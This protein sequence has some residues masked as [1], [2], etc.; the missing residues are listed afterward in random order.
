MPQD[1]T[2]ANW[3][4]AANH[5]QELLKRGDIELDEYNKIQ[6]RAKQEAAAMP[7]LAMP[8]NAIGAGQLTLPP[9]PQQSAGPPQQPQPLGPS[10][11]GRAVPTQSM[12]TWDQVQQFLRELSGSRPAY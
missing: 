10:A 5:A 4:E 2:F 8:K 12:P 11:S 6:A 9:E 1:Y 7:K 3:T